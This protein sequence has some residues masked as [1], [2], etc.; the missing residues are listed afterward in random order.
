MPNSSAKNR[1]KT[2]LTDRFEKFPSLKQDSKQ[3][4]PFPAKVYAMSP[5]LVFFRFTI[6]DKPQIAYAIPGRMYVNGSENLLKYGKSKDLLLAL[7]DP[8]M[9]FKIIVRELAETRRGYM[10]TI[11]LDPAQAEL[12]KSNAEAPNAVA[13]YVNLVCPIEYNEELVVKGLG[14]QQKFHTEDHS[15]KKYLDQVH[16]G[17][18]GG[19]MENVVL[20]QAWFMVS[21]VGLTHKTIKEGY[22]HPVKKGS[23]GK[24]KEIFLPFGGT[25]ELD[26]GQ[27]QV[28]FYRMNLYV[29]GVRV[30]F[31][32][33]LEDFIKVGDRVSLDIAPNMQQDGLFFGGVTGTNIATSVYKGDLPKAEPFRVPPKL[34]GDD[35]HKVNVF[36]LNLDPA[37]T[38]AYTSGVAVVQMSALIHKDQASTN[39]IGEFA[40]FSN[41]DLWYCG[42][43][44]AGVDLSYLFRPG[45]T[46][47][48]QLVMLPVKDGRCQYS[49]KC[50]FHGKLDLS[51]F[52]LPESGVVHKTMLKRNMDFKSFE[53]VL[54][55]KVKPRQKTI[56]EG[57]AIGRLHFLEPAENKETVSK[58]T[59]LIEAGPH[60]G[61]IVK[62]SRGKVSVMGISLDNCDLLYCLNQGEI[63]YVEVGGICDY[64]E[65]QYVSQFCRLM[66]PNKQAD[67][68]NDDPMMMCTENRTDFIAWLHQRNLPYNLFK[69]VKCKTAPFKYFIPFPKDNQLSGRVIGLDPIRNKHGASAG[70]ITV[71]SGLMSVENPAVGQLG[72]KHMKGVKVTFHRT[73][74]WVFGRKMAK[75]DLTYII[76]PGQRVMLECAEITPQEREHYPSLPTHIQYRATIVWVGP[77]RPR[78]DKDDPNRNDVSVFDW[79]SKRGLNINQFNKLVEGNMPAH[80]PMELDHRNFFL[81][82]EKGSGNVM[83]DIGGMPEAMPV[84]RHG[85]QLAHILDTAMSSTGPKDPRLFH[86]LENDN[87]AQAAHHVAEALKTAIGYYREKTSGKGG[88]Y[89]PRGPG[90]MAPKRGGPPT[91]GGPNKRARGGFGFR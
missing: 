49:V 90:G 8:D 5:T 45:D 48:A 40:K 32:D 55:K 52:P 7:L 80:N 26:D 61:K 25:I 76:Q 30:G 71:D 23:K 69:Q 31:T 47:F 59:V 89:G 68:T 2:M 24:V 18:L 50:G 70:T 73:N 36:E 87:M 10:N 86:L 43:N 22:I 78:N 39:M 12:E 28:T 38:G 67:C 14:N 74:F 4:G 83:D 44:M 15:F 58:G 60:K 13:Y 65:G 53:D 29:N 81:P 46:F 41:K 54:L 72:I 6:N 21:D 57:T 82:P 3:M 11:I 56:P 17:L 9:D 62:M 35:S 34:V 66:A 84:L 85:P 42:V 63:M 33:R 88:G 91:R 77:S 79:L 19:K 37:G 20:E 64:P 27:E 75:A 1:G 16:H 51:P